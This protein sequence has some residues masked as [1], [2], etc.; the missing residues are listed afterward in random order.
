MTTSGK[1]GETFHI[2][3]RKLTS[4]FNVREKLSEL[5][6]EFFMDAYESGEKVD[7]IKVFVGTTEIYDGRHRYEAALRLHR[8]D[9]SCVYVKQM[10]VAEKYAGAFGEN[11]PRGSQ[12]PTRG[13]AVY[14]MRQ[15]LEQGVKQ[16]QIKDLFAP[17]YF[18][19]SHADALL[20]DAKREIDQAKVVKAVQAVA[21]GTITAKAAAEKYGANPSAV[22]SAL[23]GRK[24][25]DLS[26]IDNM[27]KK[28]SRT[29]AGNSKRAGTMIG[30]AL[31]Q[32]QDGELSG[33]KAQSLI[34]HIA[35]LYQTGL[36]GLDKSY[37]KLKSFG[38][39]GKP[40]PKVKG[41]RGRRK[42][43]L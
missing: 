39:P 21:R 32:V 36:T 42:K 37:E 6:V 16:A 43:Q 22:K 15:M 26:D 18:R 34:N 20:K 29:F 27:K 28:L 38:G 1:V 10:E 9:V 3:P 4:T 41:K 33:E 31:A 2:S 13:D 8:K 25:N 12:P 14:T 17:Q 11:N 30:T 5:R 7:D 40:E 24:E 35:K 19:P 23:S